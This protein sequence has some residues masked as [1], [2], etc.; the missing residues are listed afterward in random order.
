MSGLQNKN[1]VKEMHLTPDQSM[2]GSHNSQSCGKWFVG[3]RKT[4]VENITM[5]KNCEKKNSSLA[6]DLENKTNKIWVV[7]HEFFLRDSTS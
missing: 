4:Q 1:F 7:T 3:L 2:Q 5:A 6:L